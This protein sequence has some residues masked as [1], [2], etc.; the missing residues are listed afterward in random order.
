VF[1]RGQDLTREQMLAFMVNFGTPCMDPISVVQG[2]VPDEATIHELPTRSYAP[3]T[4]VWH[5]DSSLGATPAALMALRA[6]EVPAV[7]GDTCW[8]S[9]YAAYEALSA[10]MQRC[11]TGSCVA[12]AFKV[13]PLMAG[14][15]DGLLRKPESI[16]PVVRVHPEPDAKHCSPTSCGLSVSSSCRQ[17]RAARC[18]GSCPTREVPE[19]SIRWHWRQHDLAF[20]DNRSFAHPARSTTTPST[21]HAKPARR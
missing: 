13:L 1:F 3:A 7:G 21:G 10:P 19:F 17:P 12:P 20:W 5:I 18:S 16:H 2:P 15:A 14:S 8:A 6:V 11:S 9:M 4:A